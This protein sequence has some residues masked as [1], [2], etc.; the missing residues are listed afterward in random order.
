VDD[1]VGER[2]ITDAAAAGWRVV[3]TTNAAGRAD[4]SMSRC[5]DVAVVEIQRRRASARR[6]DFIFVQRYC[7]EHSRLRG[8]DLVDGV[9]RFTP[10]YVAWLV[11]RNGRT[12]SMLQVRVPPRRSML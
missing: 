11:R 7:A 6:P 2:M 4:C 3:T 12:S 5:R 10:A 9:V 8:V 1:C